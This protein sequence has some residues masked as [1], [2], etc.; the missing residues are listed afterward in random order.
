M[1][2]VEEDDWSR[3]CTPESL[4]SAGVPPQELYSDEEEDLDEMLEQTIAVNI[5]ICLHCYYM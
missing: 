5:S 1:S 2:E 4:A 3:S